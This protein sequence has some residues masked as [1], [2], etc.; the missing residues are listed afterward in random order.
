V[1]NINKAASIGAFRR[2]RTAFQS[3]PCGGSAM[4]RAVHILA[5]GAFEHSE[6]DVSHV[7]QG[8]LTTTA[9]NATNR[10]QKLKPRRSCERLLHVHNVAQDSILSTRQES[11][12]PLRRQASLV[13]HSSNQP[14]TRK[15]RPSQSMPGMPANAA[16]GSR[17]S[18]H[19][20][21]AVPAAHNNHVH[22]CEIVLSL[23][24]RGRFISTRCRSHCFPCVH[25]RSR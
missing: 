17:D 14:L 7:N 21:S 3:R 13:V 16:S 20:S 23:D 15:R 6:P 24:C 11:S 2:Q 5:T 12:V 10:Q 22:A 25:D 18:A 8:M 4:T 9:G 19:T 1:H